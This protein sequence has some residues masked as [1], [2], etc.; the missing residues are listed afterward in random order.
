MFEERERD[1]GPRHS[2]FVG[3]YT[4]NILHVLTGPMHVARS[5]LSNN[6]S[7]VCQFMHAPMIGHFQ[8]V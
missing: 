7:N 4:F 8:V 5:N 3:L 6:V 2:K 1:G